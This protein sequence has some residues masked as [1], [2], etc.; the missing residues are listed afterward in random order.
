V[1]H[2]HVKLL[3]ADK[4]AHQTD[5]VRQEQI[6]RRDEKGFFGELRVQRE[7][8]HLGDECRDAKQAARANARKC[9]C[10]RRLR[11]PPPGNSA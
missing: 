11:R 10:G 2:Y 7:D 9:G 1:H 3:N 4:P 6:K 5:K 8:R